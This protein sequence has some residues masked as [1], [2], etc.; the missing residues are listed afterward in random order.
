MIFE[1]YD[2]KGYRHIVDLKDV[3]A[4]GFREG[5]EIEVFKREEEKHED[6]KC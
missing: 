3:T 4:F 1:Y 5:H 6:R 2:K